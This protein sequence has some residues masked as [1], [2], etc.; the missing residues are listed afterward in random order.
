LKKF[1]ISPISEN[2]PSNSGVDLTYLSLSDSPYANFSCLSPLLSFLIRFIVFLLISLYPICP[3]IF[4]SLWRGESAGERGRNVWAESFP[5]FL[6]SLSA[7]G[8][9]AFVVFF[10]LLFLLLSILEIR[11][12]EEGK[13]GDGVLR[14][15]NL[16]EKCGESGGKE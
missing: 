12:G 1:E 16:K 11:G 4:L 6:S 10:L 14:E 8:G 5:S 13:K 15:T 7:R 9:R 2:P 3:L